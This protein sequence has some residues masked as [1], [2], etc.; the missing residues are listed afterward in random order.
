MAAQFLGNL[1]DRKSLP[2]DGKSYRVS[3]IKTNG[4]EKRG[5]CGRKY[6]SGTVAQICGNYF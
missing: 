5:Y 6:F 4:A 2:E 3:Y 1:S